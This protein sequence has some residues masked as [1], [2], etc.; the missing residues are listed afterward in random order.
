MNP[1]EVKKKLDGVGCGFCLAKWTQVTM[2]L[3]TGMTHSC[4]H[5][6]PHKIPLNELKRNPSALHNTK[7]KKTR[8]KE[9][10]EGKRP[11]ECNYC[12]N[13][14][15]NSNSYSDRVFKS[16]EPWS[17]NDF[18][19]I[20]DSYWRDDFNPRYVEVSFGNTC[21]FACAYCGP[22][23]SSKWVEEIEKHGGYPT[24]HNF[25]SIDDIKARDQMPYKQTEHNPYIEAF[26]EWWPSL[27]PDLHTFR[28]TGGEPL[29][30]K[31]T[32]KVLEYI[33]KHH[34]QNS[35]ISLAINTNLGVPDKL[36]E[37]FITIAKDLCENNKVRELIIFTSVEGT[38]KQA[39]YTRYGL[40]Y[41]K[42]WSN[43]DKVL[44]ELPKVTINIMAT[45]N[46]LSVFTYSDLIDRVFE[47][48][49]KYANGE[50]YWVSALQLDTSYL[51]WPTHLSVKILEEEHKDLILKSAEKAL[52]YGIKEFTQD[53]YGFSNVEIQ[54]IKR[55]YDYAT[56]STDFNQDKYRKD[57][58]KFVDEYDKRRDTNFVETFPELKSM[59][60]KVK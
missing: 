35:N 24:E 30:L 53:N 13:V 12:W 46:A 27:F 5:P 7:H 26:W 17:I 22:Q 20:K 10:L 47:Y 23:Y 43:I 45:F 51:R 49:K 54:K 41:D 59:Y 15:D 9:M 44:T 31:D 14:E 39:E 21:N 50:R 58:V 2:H 28:I 4:H 56:G 33:Q 6:S 34:N 18:D 52:Y 36:L 3:G 16:T 11:S 38:N 8:R 1:T 60:D 37:K 40:E 42:F 29:L 32:F 48:K 25:N 55:I 57:F 19:K